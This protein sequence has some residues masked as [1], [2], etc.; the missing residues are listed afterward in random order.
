MTET[1]M[2]AAEA[3]GVAL[4]ERNSYEFAFHVLP[5]VAE[6]EVK[7]VLE[8]IK[9][10]ITKEGAEIISEEVPERIELAY[11]VVKH[12]EGK[13]RRFSSA[14]FGWIRFKL[15]GEKLEILREELDRDAA[16]LRSLMIKLTKIEETRPFRFHE[17]RKSLKMVEV[18]EEDPE[19][20]K[21]VKT[22]SE[23]GEV[24]EAELEESLEKITEEGETKA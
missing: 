16:I 10:Q 21:E 9:S 24:S 17:Q 8:R 15:V 6:G 4:D 13:N 5:T 18:V 14:Y 20:L 12:M 23:E 2:P 22:E 7:E 19:I 3:T 1:T 11:P